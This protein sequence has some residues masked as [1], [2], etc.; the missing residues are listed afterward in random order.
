[1]SVQKYLCGPSFEEKCEIKVVVYCRECEAPLCDYSK[2]D[3]ARITASKRHKLCELEDVPPSEIQE[4]LK[5]LI[6]CPNHDKDEVV[7]LCKDHDTTCCNKCAMSDHRKCEEVKVL[8]DFVHDIKMD[9]SGVRTLLHDLKPQGENLLEHECKHEEFVS[10]IESKALSSL[11]TIKQKLLDMYAQLK[12]EVLSAISDK[13][14]VI[15]EKK[16][17]KILV[18]C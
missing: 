6:A 15:G 9:C 17:K 3:H 16:I 12:N 18:S 7:Y 5:N 14:K 13:K 1:M 8:S 10:E 2:R 11:K 4:L